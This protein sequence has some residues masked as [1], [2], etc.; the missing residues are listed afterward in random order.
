MVK[1][2]M[3]G[4]ASPLVAFMMDDEDKEMEQADTDAMDQDLDELKKGGNV[5]HMEEE[6]KELE[7]V[8]IKLRT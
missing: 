7:M 6:A 3:I 5:T 8:V 1:Q 4:L 2:M